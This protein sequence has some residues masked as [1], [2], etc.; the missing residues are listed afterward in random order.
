MTLAGARVPPAWML[1]LLVGGVAIAASQVVAEMAPA[2]SW[3][4]FTGAYLAINIS[5]VAAL[6]VGVRRCTTG[7]KA[8]KLVLANQ[9]VYFLGDFFFY[10]GHNGWGWHSYPCVADI[11]Y[12]GHY[13]LLVGGLMMMIRNRRRGRDLANTADG[14]IAGIGFGVLSW[15]LLIA[16]NVHAAASP[17]VKLISVAY[18]V[19]DFVTWFVAIRLLVGGR[20]NNGSLRLL[21][22]ALGLLFVTD[23]IYT[24]LQVNGEYSA[25]K[26]ID[27]MWLGYYVLIGAAA[28]HPGMDRVTE[29]VESGRPRLGRFVTLGCLTL[30]TPAVG[31]AQSYFGSSRDLTAVGW[32]SLI[33]FVVVAGRMIGLISSQQHLLDANATQA[34]E[35]ASALRAAQ[36]VQVDRARLLARTVDSVERE[37][38]R[39]A[40]EL[41]DGPMQHL[42]T[43]GYT[44][45]RVLMRLERGDSNSTGPLLHEVRDSLSAELVAL[46]HVIGDL[47]PPVLDDGGLLL[48]LREHVCAFSRTTGIAVDFETDIEGVEL[49]AKLELVLYRA[50][51]ET[52][53]NARRHSQA[54]RVRIRLQG[55]GDRVELTV[56]DDGI[57]F[58]TRR[59]SQLVR[60]NHFGLIGL[61]ER[62]RAVEGEVRISSR[63]GHGTRV[64]AII[65]IPA[66]SPA[67]APL[68]ST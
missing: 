61:R 14:L 30:L 65:P 9:V 12:L 54:R 31:L 57:G 34:N 59:M 42:A 50:V 46:R 66:H 24:W 52:L 38:I 26:F 68:V 13:P 21:L 43:A 51:Q 29:P 55:C 39:I 41:H 8:W 63:P 37:R 53:T 25:D 49:P 5:S 18:P 35:L 60:E 7:K 48:A 27:V 19:F 32:G 28:L 1:Y 40:A 56:S 45:D 16:P 2:R 20:T 33:L 4:P 22:I 67:P 17:G 3:V 36:E 47:R 11:F 62:I 58:D 64:R 10:V 44:I 23:G 15:V 6:A